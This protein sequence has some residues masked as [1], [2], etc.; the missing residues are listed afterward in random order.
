MHSS[1]RVNLSELQIMPTPFPSAPNGLVLI[2]SNVL[3]DDIKIKGK[4]EWVLEILFLL[5]GWI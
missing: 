2:K 4:K 3:G 1:L 5:F